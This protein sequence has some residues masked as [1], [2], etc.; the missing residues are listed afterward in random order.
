MWCSNSMSFGA[1]LGVDPGVR[2]GIA[3]L[4]DSGALIHAQPLDPSM[5]E[6]ELVGRIKFMADLLAH[7]GAHVCFFE[8][9]QYMRGDGG[10]GAFTFGGINGLLRGALLASGVKLCYIYPAMWQ[11]RLGCLT[12]GNKNVTKAAAQKLFPAVKITHAI[13][14]ALLI[15][16]Y[17]R[18]QLLRGEAVTL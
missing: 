13:A 10:K 2:G 16:E 3:L 4:Q 1:V 8:K 17:G 12:G 15:A 7:Y 5:T 11:A 14:D 6:T 9:V 18:R